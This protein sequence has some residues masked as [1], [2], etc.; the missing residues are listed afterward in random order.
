MSEMEIARAVFL[1]LRMHRGKNERNQPFTVE[2][3][4]AVYG[5]LLE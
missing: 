5:G 2:D 1:A 3:V 4:R